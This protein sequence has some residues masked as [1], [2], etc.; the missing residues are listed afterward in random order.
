MTDTTM[1]DGALYLVKRKVPVF[2]LFHPVFE[3]DTVRC[4]CG[5]EDCRDLG[6]HP[7]TL[8]G[9]KDA[10]THVGRVIARWRKYPLANVGLATSATRPVLD[11]DPRHGGDETLR[12]LEAEHGAIPDGLRMLT[13]GGGMHIPMTAPA[14]ADIRNSAGKLGPGLDIRGRDGYI[15][16]PPSLHRSG[17]RYQ[18]ANDPNTMK[19]VRMPDWM[20]QLLSAP[21]IKRRMS[22][23]EVQQLVCD[24]AVPHGMQTESCMKLIGHL[25]GRNIDAI[26]V[27]ELVRSWSQTHCEPPMELDHVDAMIDRFCEQK[28][29]EMT[30]G[31]ECD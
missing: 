13:G 19:P 11:I 27:R 26:V 9:H 28:I 15:C 4:S 7:M 14:N 2:P 17:R 8:R 24:N 1:L 16:A 22:V 30:R 25:L 23:E 18:W 29:R 10:T 20:V 3:G 21:K 31:F 6:K 5:K 12:K